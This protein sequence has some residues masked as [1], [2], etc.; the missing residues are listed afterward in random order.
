METDTQLSPVCGTIQTVMGSIP[1]MEL[2]HVLI[3]E[4]LLADVTPRGLFPPDTSRVEITLDNVWDARYHWCGHYG[5]QILD[6]QALMIAELKTLAADGCTCLV[7]QTS[8][9]LKPD[10][11]GLAAISRESGVSVVAGTGFYT[12]EFAG[13][14]LAN[15]N[16]RQITDRLVADLR[17]G[18]GD[19]EIRAG[20][21]G[22]MGLSTPPHH[23]EIKALEAAC[24]AQARTGA[25]MCIHPPRDPDAPL[26]IVKMVSRPAAAWWKKPLSPT[27]NGPS[28]PSGTI[29]IWPG[30]TVFSSWTFSDWSRGSI[31]FP[32][33]TC[34]TM[35]AAWQ[36]FVPSSKGAP[37][38]DTHHLRIFAIYPACGDTGARATATSSATWCQ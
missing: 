38:A 32:P 6:D 28:P 8:R 1:A 10:P 15:L 7:E 2:N 36:S 9:G 37:G 22:E 29:W 18:M 5:N 34:P 30:Q 27:W 4:H 35:P 12:A 14:D 20:F 13:K 3:H 16:R 17:H 23:D 26:D 25:G 31:R 21:I 19:T 33:S 24:R 11:Q